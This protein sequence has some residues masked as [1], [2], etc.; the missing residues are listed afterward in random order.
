[1]DVAGR[2][3][4]DTLGFITADLPGAFI[5]DTLYQGYKKKGKPQ[6]RSGRMTSRSRSRGRSMLRTPSTTRKKRKASVSRSKSKAR[7]HS[8]SKSRGRHSKKENAYQEQNAEAI[9]KK[10][11]KVTLRKHKEPHVSKKFRLAVE[12]ALSPKEIRGDMHL[13]YCSSIYDLSQI[14]NDAQGY[15]DT[16]NNPGLDGG[17]MFLLDHFKD[18]YSRMWFGKVTSYTSGFL[19]PAHDPTNVGYAHMKFKIIDSYSEFEFKNVSLRTVIL[20]LWE[21]KPKTNGSMS[22][23]SPLSQKAYDDGGVEQVLLDS[24]TT[25]TTQWYNAL[26]ADKINNAVSDGEGNALDPTKLMLSPQYSKS[27]KKQFAFSFREVILESGQTHKFKIQGPSE[28]SIDEEKCFKNSIWQN[29]RTFS[30]GLICA[31]YQ[32]LTIALPTSGAPTVGG[33]IKDSASS[34]TNIPFIAMERQDHFTLEMQ[35]EAVGPNR[36]PVMIRGIYSA[37]PS[38]VKPAE[39]KQQNPTAMVTE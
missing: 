16:I 8:R 30:R 11:K 33:R 1:M 32:D 4:A 24:Y 17:W 13:I 20:R 37:N 34:N 25:P 15:W 36:H 12:A 3:A 39:V 19:T 6:R 5:A 2:V 29:V 14:S 22:V 38:S 7:G 9:V 21:V 18:A 10:N 35:E 23:N 26:A 28:I 31:V 27:M